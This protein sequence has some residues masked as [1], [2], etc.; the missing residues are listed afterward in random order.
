MLG[1]G[2]EPADS[3]EQTENGREQ[4]GIGMGQ[5]TDAGAAGVTEGEVAKGKDIPDNA[6]P[7][8]AV[9]RIIHPPGPITPD[10]FFFDLGVSSM[11]LDQPWRGFSFQPGPL[12]MRMEQN[13]S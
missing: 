3:R 6:T 9:R 7:S 10:L 12:D 8:S 13:V 5:T 4:T 2:I 11:Q 1:V